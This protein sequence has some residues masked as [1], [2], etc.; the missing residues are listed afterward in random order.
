MLLWKLFS[1]AVKNDLPKLVNVNTSMNFL[2]QR[3]NLYNIETS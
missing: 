3:Q 2:P 1:F